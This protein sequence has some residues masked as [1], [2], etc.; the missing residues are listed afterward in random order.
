MTTDLIALTDRMPDPW[1]LVAGLMSGGP[2][3]RVTV[4]GEGAVIRLTDDEGRPLAYVEAPFLVH[5]PGEVTRLLGVDVAGPVWWTEVRAATAARHAEALASTIATRLAAL[6]G[7]TVWPASATAPDGGSAPVTGLATAVAHA[8]EQPSVDVLT[9]K[10][11][12]VIQD[13]PI[14]AMTAWLSDALRATT[15]SE[16]GLQIVTPRTARLSFP[17]RVALAGYPNRWVVKD[18]R[19][20]YHDGLTGAELVWKE[21]EFTSTQKMSQVWAEAT[22]RAEDIGEQQLLVT[23]TT[24]LPAAHDLVVG[25]G[26]EAAWRHV[27]DGAEPA[28]WG[29]AEPAGATWSREDLTALARQRVPDPLWA[30]ASGVRDPATLGDAAA[31]L[32]AVRIALTGGGVEEDVTFAVGYPAGA[33]PPLG[34]LRALAAELVTDHNLVSMLVQRRRARADLT[35]PAHLEPAPAPVAFVLGAEGVRSIGRDAAAHPPLAVRPTP[36]GT[37][38][39][40]GLYYP[41]ADAGWQGFQELM[42]HLHDLDP[43]KKSA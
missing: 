3:T 28:G 24:R 37:R 17:T 25:G 40:R 11:A 22:A 8:A 13:R 18:G 4:A 14:V 42:G 6:L 30:V 26:L 29:S 21:G 9:D 43:D 5:T 1:S 15:V 41:L 23:F 10:V 31:V 32:A 16:R 38:A 19:G 35:I 20:G 27:L 34:T 33:E 12:V 2:D 39:D 36:L 7:G